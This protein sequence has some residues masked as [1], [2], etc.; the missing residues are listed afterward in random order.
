M[1]TF[2]F[3]Y[4]SS[5]KKNVA[6]QAKYYIFKLKFSMIANNIKTQFSI[7]FTWSVRKLRI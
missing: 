6:T 3:Y 2:N 1:K 7:Y 4:S 5:I